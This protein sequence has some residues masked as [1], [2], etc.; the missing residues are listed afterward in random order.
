MKIRVICF[1]FC[2]FLSS[3]SYGQSVKNQGLY[4]DS[5]IYEGLKRKN[6]SQEPRV[7]NQEQRIKSQ[8]EILLHFKFVIQGIKH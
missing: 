1:C 4:T 7:K 6:K 3:L 8:D 5:M 2:L